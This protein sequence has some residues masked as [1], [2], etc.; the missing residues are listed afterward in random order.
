MPLPDGWQVA[1]RALVLPKIAQRSAAKANAESGHCFLHCKVL[2]AALPFPELAVSLQGEQ[3]G[4]LMVL[5]AS[6]GGRV[7]VVLCAHVQGM[8]WLYYPHCNGDAADTIESAHL[9]RDDMESATRLDPKEAELNEMVQ[10]IHRNESSFSQLLA[11]AAWR[12]EEHRAF[13]RGV[14][15]DVD[16]ASLGYEANPFLWQRG[17]KEHVCI[18]WNLA[19][20]PNPIAADEEEVSSKLRWDRLDH[21]L[22]KGW[23]FPSPRFNA[24]QPFKAAELRSMLEE[25]AT[26]SYKI[27]GCL[28]SYLGYLVS[29]NATTWQGKFEPDPAKWPVPTRQ[30]SGRQTS[31]IIVWYQWLHVTI[32][33]AKKPHRVSMRVDHAIEGHREACLVP[34]I[35][36]DRIFWFSSPEGDYALTGFEVL[37]DLRDMKLWGHCKYVTAAMLLRHFRNAADTTDVAAYGDTPENQEVMKVHVQEVMTELEAVAETWRVDA[38]IDGT[39]EFIS[40]F[41]TMSRKERMEHSTK[42]RE[43]LQKFL[44]V[45]CSRGSKLANC[46]S[47]VDAAL[48]TFQHALANDPAEATKQ[49]A[50]AMSGLSTSCA[51]TAG[52]KRALDET[53]DLSTS[54]NPLFAAGT[55]VIFQNLTKQK[56]LEDQTGTVESY[57][58]GTLRYAVR[59]HSSGE[60]ARVLERCLRTVQTVV[61]DLDMTRGPDLSSSCIPMF[62]AGTVVIFQ[63]LIKRLDLEDQSGTVESY[64]AGTAR[65]AVRI[66]SS[67]ERARVLERCLRHVQTVVPALDT[68][69]LSPKQARG[70]EEC[71]QAAGL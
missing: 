18:A 17:S 42:F 46:Y 23:S 26:V 11:E 15:F 45:S 8:E 28:C 36:T 32:G 48:D 21:A 38:L 51:P 4:S 1:F 14:P 61:P 37:R 56:Y 33:P 16:I 44:S 55:I 63:N 49:L 71:H 40:M 3:V 22:S 39:E 58:V 2:G 13:S 24:V 60:R 29:G 7:A 25:K 52:C 12:A 69:Q 34:R 41:S 62:A 57:D 27:T 68:A 70:P 66:H 54:C 6:G 5:A 20:S 53:P 19:D 67:G 10:F 9:V 50:H 65:Y 59:I 64:D 35:D 31:K 30:A 43:T 47:V